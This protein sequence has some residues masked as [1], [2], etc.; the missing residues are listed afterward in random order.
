MKQ[1]ATRN[2]SIQ[3]SLF[4]IPL[5]TFYVYIRKNN[6]F[7]NAKQYILSLAAK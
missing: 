6:A 7:T 1:A 2:Q 5:S 3:T 4:F